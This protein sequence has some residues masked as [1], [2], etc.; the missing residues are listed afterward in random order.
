MGEPNRI[1]QVSVPF[2]VIQALDDPLISW[3]T[4]GDPKE[5]VNSGSGNIMMLLTKS[6]GHVGWPL[7]MNPKAHGWKWMNN[8]ASDFVVSL[9]HVKKQNSN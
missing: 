3:R 1:S 2:L 8:C 6:G 4:L 5:V 9:H 7:G